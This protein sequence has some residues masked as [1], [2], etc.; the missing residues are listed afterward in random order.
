MAQVELIQLTKRY[1]DVLAV[2]N[3][4]LTVEDKE[5]LVLLGPSGC[6][7]STIL[8]MI[9]GLEPISEGEIYIDEQL[10][11]QQIWGLI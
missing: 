11:K 2:N 1:K 5:F 9:A 10:V 7:K 4:T 3:V 6:G 8:K